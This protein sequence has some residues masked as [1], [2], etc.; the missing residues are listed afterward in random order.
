M[1]GLVNMR[2]GKKMQM[3][4]NFPYEIAKNSLICNLST[5]YSAKANTYSFP[6]SSTEYHIHRN[7]FEIL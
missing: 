6:L 1:Y 7:I 3:E 5:H 2:T 4:T